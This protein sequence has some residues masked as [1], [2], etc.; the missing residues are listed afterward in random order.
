[1]SIVMVKLDM[2]FW[3]WEMIIIFYFWGFRARRL[4]LV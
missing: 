1:M 2:R 4:A 3:S